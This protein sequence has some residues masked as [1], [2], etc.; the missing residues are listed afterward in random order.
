MNTATEIRNQATAAID[1]MIGAIRAE[2]VPVSNE[3]VTFLK[4]NPAFL[5]M[6]AL[7]VVCR[8]PSF[9]NIF[10]PANNASGLD[11]D[12][13]FHQKL[14]EEMMSLGDEKIPADI[15]VSHA[16]GVARAIVRKRFSTDQQYALMDGYNEVPSSVEVTNDINFPAHRS[17]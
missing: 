2:G 17:V 9:V 3:Q 8:A 1:Q 4:E 11:I 14:M 6:P 13:K 15:H 7:R 5:S 16:A 10:D 12:P